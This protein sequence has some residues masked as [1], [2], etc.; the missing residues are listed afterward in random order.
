MVVKEFNS[1]YPGHTV[2]SVSVTVECA[3]D[4]ITDTRIVSV[5]TGILCKTGGNKFINIHPLF[6]FKDTRDYEKLV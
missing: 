1:P 6:I 2:E 5:H 4:T 3:D